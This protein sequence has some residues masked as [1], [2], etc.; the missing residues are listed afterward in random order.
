MCAT[1][2]ISITRTHRVSTYLTTGSDLVQKC[3]LNRQTKHMSAY[4][5]I[6][7]DSLRDMSDNWKFS[8]Y[9]PECLSACKICQ[10]IHLD[11]IHSCRPCCRIPYRQNINVRNVTYIIAQSTFFC[12]SSNA[13]CNSRSRV[14]G[15]DNLNAPLLTCARCNVQRDK[16]FSRGVRLREAIVL[17]EVEQRLLPFVK[18][19]RI[20]NEQ[21]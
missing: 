18:L 2:C 14:N 19:S 13:E 16:M 9:V 11:F 21:F 8:P 6:A 20:N 5:N 17:H 10:C 1:T 3:N 7:G 4:H 12:M 15:A